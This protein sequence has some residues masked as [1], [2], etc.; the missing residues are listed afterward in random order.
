MKLV[1]RAYMYIIT[2]LDL[3][4]GVLVV[5]AK[6]IETEEEGT[7]LEADIDGIAVELVAVKDKVEEVMEEEAELAVEEPVE[8]PDDAVVMEV[9]EVA[10]TLVVVE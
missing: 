7:G 5:P 9:E 4:T 1:V 6:V 10:G 3:E 8:K 2:D